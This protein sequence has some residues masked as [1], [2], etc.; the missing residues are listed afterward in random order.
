MEG[1]VAGLESRGESAKGAVVRYPADREGRLERVVGGGGGWVEGG[2]SMGGRTRRM[3][4]KENIH[5]ERGRSEEIIP[6]K[7]KEEKGEK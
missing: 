3:F 4:G 1:R 7:S 2:G 6:E 5:A